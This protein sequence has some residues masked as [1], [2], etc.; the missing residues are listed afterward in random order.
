VSV[1]TALRLDAL[2]V[3]FGRGPGL[4]DVA[5]SVAA[6]ERVAVVGA[7]GAGKTTLLRAIAGLAP[8]SGGR[9]FVHAPD[10]AAER[11]VTALPPERRGVVYLHQTPVL[12]PHLDVG[13]NVAFPLRV[14]GVGEASVRARVHD[15]LSLVRLDSMA[16]RAPQTLSGG[17]RH[18]V[19]LA[20]AVAARPAVL[21]LDE[22][23]AALDPSLRAEVRDAVA[24]LARAEEVAMLLVT[25]DLDEA[26]LVADRIALLIDGRLQQVA[27]PAAL[28]RAPTTLAAARFLGVADEVPGGVAA[29]GRVASALGVFIAPGG[30]WSALPI[31]AAVVI[32][33]MPGAA[34]IGASGVAAVVR[35]HRHRPRGASVRVSLA[36]AADVTLDV[37]ADDASLP[38]IGTD[39]RV[40]VDPARLLV[41]P[42]DAG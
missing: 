25:H 28:F 13:E 1:R 29:D 31:G 16:R 23:L 41:F 33:V 6:G 34:R 11:E 15:A 37:A 5:L 22:P 10:Q 39:V 3:P 40:D 18:R 4:H 14:R 8:S 35:A 27:T 19:A 24:A 26:G 38:P 17:Q 12:F 2:S 30:A 32:A 20:R 36:A 7:S 42:A 21:L 9:V